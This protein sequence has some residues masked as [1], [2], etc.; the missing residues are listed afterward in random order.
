MISENPSGRCPNPRRYVTDS[1]RVSRALLVSRATEER[2]A[3]QASSVATS[4]NDLCCFA[5]G[6][7]RALGVNALLVETG[8][9]LH[10]SGRHKR[11][12]LLCDLRRDGLEDLQSF[13]CCSVWL[14]AP[15]K[16]VSNR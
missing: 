13:A 5:I 16:T 1:V 8:G 6:V 7:N 3:A 10:A 11:L 2:F 14:S 4:Q 12:R 15:G 9:Y